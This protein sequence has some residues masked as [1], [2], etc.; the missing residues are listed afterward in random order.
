VPSSGT[1]QH[2]TD[3][4]VADGEFFFDLVEPEAMK[5]RLNEV[6]MDNWM[7]CIDEALRKSGSK[8]DGSSYTRDDV[9]YLD[10]L[11]VKPSAHRDMLERL[12]LTE[13][14]SSY[15]GS[16]G[17]IGE[18]DTIISIDEG[19]RTGALRDGDVIAAVGAGIGYVW[20][21]GILHWGPAED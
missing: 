10:M 11:L 15:L 1:I 20:A 12:G 19:L 18:Q 8:A 14:R 16:I 6:S 5:D 13:D 2:P 9:S 17:H 7:H 3:R 4:A 21:A